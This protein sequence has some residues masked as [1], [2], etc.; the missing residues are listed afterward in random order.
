MAAPITYIGPD[1]KIY[2]CCGCTTVTVDMEADYHFVNSGCIPPHTN[3]G[4]PCT[5]G[6]S[7]CIFG[8]CTCSGN[9]VVG[10]SQTFNSPYQNATITGVWT[11]FATFNTNCLDCIGTPCATVTCPFGPSSITFPATAHLSSAFCGNLVAS[12]SIFVCICGKSPAP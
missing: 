12:G 8:G 3:C 10:I 2:I 9:T 11:T 7:D 1:G 4:D 6:G 5:G